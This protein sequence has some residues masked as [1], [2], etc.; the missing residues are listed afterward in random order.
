M[1]APTSRRQAEQLMAKQKDTIV[2]ER[3]FFAE[4]G[5]KGWDNLSPKKRKERIAKQTGYWKNMTEAQR[6][7]EMKRRAKV[8]AANKLENSKGESP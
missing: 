6:K 2:F 7:T 4:A 3:S 1:L 8:R 5:R